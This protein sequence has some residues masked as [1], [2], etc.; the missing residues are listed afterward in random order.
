MK[1]NV[2]TLLIIAGCIF[3]SFAISNKTAYADEIPF[4]DPNFAHDVLSA[5]NE[6]N[7][8]QA[9]SAEEMTDEGLSKIT[10][11]HTTLDK[12]I[13]GIEKLTSLNTLHVR[14]LG[15]ILV[16]EEGLR[17]IDLSKNTSLETV[18][19]WNL[20]DLEEVIF[21]DS[22]SL[23][24][25]EFQ[26][27]DSF[28]KLDLSTYDNL[29]LTSFRLI[30]NSINSLVL[31]KN[32][33][34]LENIYIGENNIETLDL[35][36]LSNTFIHARLGPSLDSLRHIILPADWENNPDRN[37]ETTLQFSPEELRNQVTI[38]YAKRPAPDEDSPEDDKKAEEDTAK[39]PNTGVGITDTA[40]K[41]VIFVAPFIFGIF[42]ISK[43]VY[44]ANKKRVRF[45]R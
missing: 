35:S 29:N 16:D 2:R 22:S 27:C 23:R 13:S 33:S 26:A 42:I 43:R 17:K 37:L 41:I 39:V 24:H 36:S 9:A 32:T 45:S 19:F 10:Y 38:T 25:F 6:V 21:P 31:P 12:S 3:A 4:S 15:A 34:K 18:T 14:S 7:E 11:L 1:R 20:P 30:F 5:Y 40:N 28:K 44:K 8:V